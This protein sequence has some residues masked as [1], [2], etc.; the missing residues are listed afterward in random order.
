MMSHVWKG[1]CW[2]R[3]TFLTLG[4]NPPHP[5]LPP[6]PVPEKAA[7]NQTNEREVREA[8]YH[9]AKRNIVAG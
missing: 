5:L 7:Q 1:R 6:L 9:G 8:N 2:Q 3:A 4:A